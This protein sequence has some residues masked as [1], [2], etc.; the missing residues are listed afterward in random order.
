MSLVIWDCFAYVGTQMIPE[1]LAVRLVNVAVLDVHSNQLKALPNSIGCLCKL[2]LLNVAGNLLVSL[3]TTIL[4]CRFAVFLHLLFHGLQAM[5]TDLISFINY[6]V[7]VH[8]VYVMNCLDGLNLQV[9]G[10]CNCL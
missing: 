1:P 10:P 3:P 7:S 2:K 8:G 6:V 9:D 4:K 5:W